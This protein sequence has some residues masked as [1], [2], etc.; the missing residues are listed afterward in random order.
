MVIYVK[1]HS[2]VTFR[3]K[4][5][6]LHLKADGLL[7]Q[8]DDNLWKDIYEANKS[9]IDYLKSNNTIIISQAKEDKLS[10]EIVKEAVKEV[11]DNQKK[12]ISKNN[13]KK[14]K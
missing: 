8:V 3:S 1:S 10:E 4:E 14:V 12:S 2:G 11:V 13:I 6:A 5:K 9:N 7:N